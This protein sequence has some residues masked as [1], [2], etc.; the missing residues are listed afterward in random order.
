[1]CVCVYLHMSYCVEILDEL[2]LLPNKAA[3]ETFVQISGAV[4]GVD[5]TFITGAPSDDDWANT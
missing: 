3:S 4:R 1:V 2:P 5:W